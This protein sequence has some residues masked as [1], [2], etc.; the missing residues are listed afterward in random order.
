MTD[1]QPKLP[2]LIWKAMA[3]RGKLD[4]KAK[5]NLIG[6]AYQAIADSV[7]EDDEKIAEHTKNFQ[8]ILSALEKL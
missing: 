3:L 2:E 8:E 1:N 5:E 6:M 4:Q 7:I